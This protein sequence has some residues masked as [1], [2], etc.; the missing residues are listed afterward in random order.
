MASW[1]GA[2]A[3]AS[4][5]KRFRVKL[6]RCMTLEKQLPLSEAL[7]SGNNE[8]IIDHLIGTS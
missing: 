4:G 6:W 3:L 7:S 2:R 5:V 8:N 1:C